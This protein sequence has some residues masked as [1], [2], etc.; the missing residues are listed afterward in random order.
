M[1]ARRTLS[2]AGQPPAAIRRMAIGPPIGERRSSFCLVMTLASQPG[3]LLPNGGG[4]VFDMGPYY[5][6]AW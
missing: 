4:P 2:D 5:L 6:T 1:V 3:L